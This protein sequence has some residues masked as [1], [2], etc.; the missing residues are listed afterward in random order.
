MVCVQLSGENDKIWVS[1]T[2]EFV[3]QLLL[4]T[5][6]CCLESTQIVFRWRR[7]REEVNKGDGDSQSWEQVSE[8][9]VKCLTSQEGRTFHVGNNNVHMG[10]TLFYMKIPWA[11]LN[12]GF[13]V[14]SCDMNLAGLHENL[15]THPVC[16]GVAVVSQLY[17]Q[18][19]SSETNVIIYIQ[20]A[21][22]I[23]PF[24]HVLLWITW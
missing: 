3:L 19:P 9:S 12:Q 6:L 20:F 16:V 23:L 10:W 14:M 18:H 21:K 15:E 4:A 24:S 17:Y 22:M 11:A 13:K 1:S 2:D 8:A 5:T 7:Q